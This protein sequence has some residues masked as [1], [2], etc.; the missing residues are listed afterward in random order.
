MNNMGWNKD[1]A[2][3]VLADKVRYPNIPEQL[4]QHVQYCFN[5]GNGNRLTES[6]LANAEPVTKAI[7]QMFSL[8]SK[9]TGLTP[10]D[11]LRRTD[12]NYREKNPTRHESAFAEIRAIN[13]L[14]DEGFDHIEPLA[15]KQNKRADIIAKKGN[16]KYAIEVVNSIFEVDN[17][18]SSEELKKWLMGRDERDHKI[19]QLTT[20]ASEMGCQRSILI[21]IVDTWST[22][23]YQTHGDFLEASK[24][25][26][27]EMGENPQF[28]FCFVTGR[29]ALGY[30]RDDSIFPGWPEMK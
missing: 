29:C 9:A 12:F 19:E 7:N 14:H 18:Y 20:T 27:K 10:C 16:D 30:G 3:K 17:R 8:A 13:F 25:V 26:W 5:T 6:L 2:C 22:V 24:L 4:I 21:A 23:T 28:H 1:E 11:L 15:S